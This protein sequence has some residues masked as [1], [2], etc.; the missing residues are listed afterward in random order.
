MAKAASDSS[1]IR[2]LS[3]SI[4]RYPGGKGRHAKIMASIFKLNGI[5]PE[6][7][8]EPFCGGASISLNLLEAD[9]VESICLNDLDPMI[10][11]LWKTVF[12]RKDSKWLIEKVV[13]APLT[14]EYWDYQKSLM[15]KSQK[16]RAF[17]C[18]Y[19]NRT[20]FS[21]LLHKHAGP[22]GGRKQ[23]RW[24]IGCRFNQEKIAARIEKLSAYASRV[25][26][27]G[28]LNW[29]EFLAKS[30]TPSCFIYLDPPYYNKAERLYRYT[31]D[32]SQHVAMRDYLVDFCCVPW[33]LSYDD[34]KSIRDMYIQRKRKVNGCI[35]DSTYSTHPIGGNSVIGRELLF[36]NLK[37]LPAFDQTVGHS[38]IS[39]RD[40]N[41]GT[42]KFSNLIGIQS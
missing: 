37:N 33:V 6:T 31:F 16:E 5:S 32:H 3:G 28:N 42:S 40:F 34:S 41:A 25:K 4:L 8:I 35:I 39:V 15:P 26:S 12:S 11:A 24:D 19:L 17:Q 36:T 13:E 18:L 7:F 38:G 29:G 9:V 27:V 22:I 23:G 1:K 10:A 30:I 20:S 21:G 14:L 2:S